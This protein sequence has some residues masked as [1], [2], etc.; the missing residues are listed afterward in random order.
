MTSVLVHEIE[1]T[2]VKVEPRNY[3]NQTH[4]LKS[5]LLTG[6]HKRIAILYLLGVSF[7]FA[8]GGLL[9][10][11][12]RLELLTPSADMM[13]LDTYNKVFT[14]HG[15]VMIFF[16]LIPAVPA[17]LG[18]FLMPLMLGTRDLAFPKINLLSWYSFVV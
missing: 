2:A 17:V 3:L 13:A 12:L 9:A 10:F 15:I 1:T 18:N 7:F 11:A 8:V 16:V 6:D 5:W 14:M 4:G